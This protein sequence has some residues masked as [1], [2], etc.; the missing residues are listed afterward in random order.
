MKCPRRKFVD[1]DY[2][3]DVE[4]QKKDICRACPD[5]LGEEKAWGEHCDAF[6][7]CIVTG[8]KLGAE[9][10]ERLP[11]EGR[12]TATHTVS[13]EGRQ[14]YIRKLEKLKKQHKRPLW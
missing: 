1:L 11:K 5:Y 12:E 14:E 3:Q 8:K 6:L 4:Q 9:A 13:D 10:F 7:T 2:S